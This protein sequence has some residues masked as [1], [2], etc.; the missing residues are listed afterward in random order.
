MAATVSS[1]DM[2]LGEDDAV[3][4]VDADEDLIDRRDAEAAVL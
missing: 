3:N 1:F 4:V 2:A